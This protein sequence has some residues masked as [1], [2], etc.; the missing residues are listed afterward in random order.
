MRTTSLNLD[1]LP[2]KVS[3]T[4]K[5]EAKYSEVRYI[6]REQRVG[7][8][9]Y[10]IG[11]RNQ[12]TV[13]E[14]T[15]SADGKML[16]D[17]RRNVSELAVAKPAPIAED[18]PQGMPF[19]KLPMAIQK[20]TKAYA[21]ASE[22]RSV[23][24]DEYKGKAVYD[25]VF[26]RN[27]QRDRLVIG[28]DGTVLRVQENVPATAEL[29]TTTKAPVL[30]VGDLPQ[31]VQDTIRQQTQNI[32]VD[33]IGTKDI[34]GTSVYSISYRTNGA[35]VEL[36]VAGDGKVV[37]PEASAAANS[38]SAPL[39]APL[40]KDEPKIVVSTTEPER[41][42]AL[43]PAN[44]PLSEAAGRALQTEQGTD[45]SKSTSSAS[46]DEREPE[47][48]ARTVNLADV[49]APVRKSAKDLAGNGRI[50][51]ITPRLKDSGMVYQISVENNGSK[52]TLVL[53]KDGVLQTTKGSSQ[54]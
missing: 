51:S 32:R 5:K 42:T 3:A 53:N 54:P 48:P 27:G 9:I 46:L 39:P 26:Y 49:P 40:R 7:G 52:R 17:N 36:L 13:G 2:E 30:A 8:D 31:P 14:L 38:P 15:I 28:K 35:P 21:A 20:A 47:K 6:N 12:D 43:V 45:H 4:L 19:E 16:T 25:I 1:D 41:N 18:L 10:T 29:A 11:L 23:I 22:V 37:L 44:A 34:A 24:L 33:H 50:T